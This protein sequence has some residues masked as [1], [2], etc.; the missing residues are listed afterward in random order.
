M[1]HHH[2]HYWQPAPGS[3]TFQAQ[4][5]RAPLVR[6]RLTRDL[7]HRWMAG[8][9]AG[10]ARHFGWNRTALRLLTIGLFVFLLAPLL[11]FLAMA[12]IVAW[13]V[14]PG[15]SERQAGH[16]EAWAAEP[17]SRTPPPVPPTPRPSLAEVRERFRSLEDRLRSMEA[18]V[19]SAQYEIDRELGRKS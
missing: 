13:M 1:K 7:D 9:V 11:P 10:I 19:T 15:S 14:I 4:A 17:P 8:V 12:Y 6:G 16:S 18:Y 3:E 5:Q 2:Y